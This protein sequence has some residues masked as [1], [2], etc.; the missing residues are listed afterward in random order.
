MLDKEASFLNNIFKN[1]K[2]NYNKDIGLTIKISEYIIL[3][4]YTDGKHALE[5]NNEENINTAAKF[6][7]L[8]KNI[9]EVKTFFYKDAFD[10][11]VSQ[12]N[13]SFKLED[14]IFQSAFPDRY[15]QAWVEG[16]LIQ[17]KKIIDCIV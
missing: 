15:N 1:Y 4:V 3:V 7:N 10:A 5:M 11:V 6:Y 8:D 12:E 2:V 13:L 14:R 16:N 17:S 9:K